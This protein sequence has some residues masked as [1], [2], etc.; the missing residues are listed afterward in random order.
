MSGDPCNEVPDTF[1]EL[2]GVRRAGGWQRGAAAPP[3]QKDKHNI[4]QGHQ[5]Q[6]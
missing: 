2:R 6:H 3:P 4:S 1:L 5:I